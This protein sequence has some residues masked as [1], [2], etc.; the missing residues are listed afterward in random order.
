MRNGTWFISGVTRLGTAI[1]IT[2][3]QSQWRKRRNGAIATE[4]GA[5]IGTKVAALNGTVMLVQTATIS[6]ARHINIISI[7]KAASKLVLFGFAVKTDQIE[8]WTSTSVLFTHL[9]ILKFVTR[10]NFYVHP[11][12][13]IFRS[14]FLLIYFAQKMRASWQGYG[15]SLFFKWQLFGWWKFVKIQTSTLLFIMLKRCHCDMW[16]VFIKHDTLGEKNT[17]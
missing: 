1:I 12:F 5:N 17:I 2:V 14:L 6:G 13:F 7:T 8:C 11:G 9:I 10:V 15:R 16:T 3:S 4:N